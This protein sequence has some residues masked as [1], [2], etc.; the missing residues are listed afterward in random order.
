[1]Q[2]V[3][4]VVSLCSSEK[5]LLM[6]DIIY[7]IT[8]HQ[9]NDSI[10]L[11]DFWMAFENFFA[12]FI[13]SITTWITMAYVRAPHAKVPFGTTEHARTTHSLLIIRR[14]YFSFGGRSQVLCFTYEK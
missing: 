3:P 9:K 2:T 10:K 6:Y 8:G 5:T 13:L 14:L 11:L 7:W 4:N 12:N 1:M